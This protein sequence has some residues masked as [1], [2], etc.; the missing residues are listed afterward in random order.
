M[1]VGESPELEPDIRVRLLS[2]VEFQEIL[3]ILSG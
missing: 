3:F 1:N 2:R